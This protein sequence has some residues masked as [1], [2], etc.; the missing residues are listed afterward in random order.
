MHKI[1]DALRHIA[2]HNSFIQ[3]GLQHRLL[4][5]SQLARFL[6]PLIAAR[7][8]KE[9]GA[10]ALHMSLSRLQ[11]TMRKT[12]R[13][14]TE[15]EFSLGQ[16]SV[17]PNLAILTVEKN[18]E[19]Q[20]R[21]GLV[22][23]KVQNAGG[24]I[25]ITE[26]LSEITMI[27]DRAML[28]EAIEILKTKPLLKNERVAAISAKFSPKYVRTPGFLF[29]ILQCLYFQSINIVEISST[30]TEIIFYLAESEVKLAFDTLYNKF[31]Q[32]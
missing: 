30:S 10:S 9:V 14:S 8:K 1:S 13:R 3:Y 7:T 31:G 18:R 20:R 23:T 27:L 25:T 15:S 12:E 22:L 32:R 4:N 5:L 24:Y 19:T 26:G 17:Q 21:A 11:G 6:Q 2:E 16:I 29:S 28:A